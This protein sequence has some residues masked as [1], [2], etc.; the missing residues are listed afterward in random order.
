VSVAAFIA[1]QRARHQ[2]PHAVSCRALGVSQAWFY[3]WRR[4]DASP[5]RERRERLKAEVAR[6]FRLQD[7]K[8]GSPRITADLRDAGW[9]VSVNTVA[10][11]M[12]EQGLAARAKRK[13]RGAT[14]QGKGRWRAP[15]LVRRDFSAGK[16]NEKWFGDGTEITTDEGKLHLASVLD[17]GSRRIVGFAVSG[18]HDAEL[19]YGALAMAAA[20]RGGSVAGVVFHTDQGSEHTAGTVRA[21]CGRLGIRQSM[22]RPGSAPDNAAI[23][24]WHSTLEF[25]LRS[26]EHFATRAQARARIAAWID[27]YNTVRR[28]SAIGM[29]SPVAFEAGQRGRRAA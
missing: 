29:I 15:D 20:V 14:R 4:G 16:V 18:H 28:H 2:V 19:A 17:I 27:E 21:A 13:R 7:G 8:C 22:G 6:V 23:E 1:A 9:K 5:R 24:S 3:K 25:E 10:R 12:R 11:V 26:R